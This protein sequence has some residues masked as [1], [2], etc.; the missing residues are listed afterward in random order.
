MITAEDVNITF[1][2]FIEEEKLSLRLAAADMHMISL[3]RGWE[4][5]SVPSKFF[6][7][8]ASGRPLLYCGTPDSC[9]ARLIN[10]HSLGFIVEANKIKAIADILEEFSHDK[11]KIHQMQEWAFQFYNTHFSKELQWAK[12]NRSLRDYIKTSH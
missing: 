4:G 8:L 1:A 6:G 3:R 5:V 9:I 7:S 11:N 2:G 10:E 12:W